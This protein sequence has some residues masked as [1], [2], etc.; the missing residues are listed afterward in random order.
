MNDVEKP[1]AIFAREIVTL[2]LH[3]LA[4]HFQH[5]PFELGQPSR[6]KTLLASDISPGWGLPPPP[7]NA[8]SEIVMVGLR[9]GRFRHQRHFRAVCRPPNESCCFQRSCKLRG[10]QSGGQS[11][12]EHGFTGAGRTDK[13]RRCAP[14]A[15]IQGTFDILPPFTS[16]KSIS[17]SLCACANS[18][19]Y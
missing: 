14:A 11:F 10:G 4:H 16:A 5:L 19:G 9:N 2:L 13:H 3:R 8:T 7:T 12:G 17:K 1:R 6:N 18:S 15:A